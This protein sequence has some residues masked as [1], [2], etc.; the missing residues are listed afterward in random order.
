MQIEVQPQLNSDTIWRKEITSDLSEEK[1]YPLEEEASY[2]EERGVEY[3]AMQMLRED[4]EYD[5]EISEEE[6]FSSSPSHIF[7]TY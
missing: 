1:D 7:S 6:D 3:S 4:A 5:D 2:F